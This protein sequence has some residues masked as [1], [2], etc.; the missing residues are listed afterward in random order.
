ML[1]AT[2]FAV[3]AQA[4]VA[5]TAIGNAGPN[6]LR[7][8][9]AG[10]VIRGKAGNDRILA[11]GGNDRT[12]GQNGH[13]RM[14]AGSGNDRQYGGRGRDRQYGGAGKDRQWGGPGAD[15]IFG[16][17]GADTGSGG[18]GRDLL[19]GGPGSDTLT[20][21]GQRDTFVAGPGSDII[22]ANDGIREIVKCGSGFD[23][24]NVDALD[25]TRGCETVNRP[26]PPLGIDIA[27]PQCG[28]SEA[29]PDDPAFVIVGVNG[30]LATTENPCLADQL[31][32]AATSATG[33]TSLAPIQVYVNTANPGGLNTESWP[34]SNLDPVTGANSPNPNGNCNGADTLACAWQYGWNRASEDAGRWF[35]PAATAAGLDASPSSYIW[36]LDVET[37][38]TWKTGGTRFD[39]DS[40]TAV[41]EGM[42]ARFAADSV[43]VG[44]YSTAA[45]WRSIV[46]ESVGSASNL[47]GL[48]NW[49]PGGANLS[50]A[51]TA[52][53]AAPLT[54]GGAVVMTQFVDDD[55]DY[56]YSCS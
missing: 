12:Y 21:G 38:N 6:V 37:E 45:Q 17:A 7:G 16:G 44:L 39:H 33:A 27:W 42:A 30:G 32:Y 23:V 5:A 53:T 48:P 31:S 50:T 22:N 8:T 10:D 52:C 13:D 24:A 54:V 9:A 25:V 28:E 26:S 43:R 1:A 55:L 34:S 4:A 56:N 35:P 19:V 14:W 49:R 36:W 41:L 15:R 18:A 3:L 11:R 2:V 29:L 47:N 20:G 40:N 46:G 51:I